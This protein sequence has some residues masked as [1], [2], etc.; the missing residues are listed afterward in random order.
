MKNEKAIYETMLSLK[1]RVT[2]IIIAHRLSTVEG[3]DTIV[4]LNKGQIHA[5]GSVSD[6]LPLYTTTLKEK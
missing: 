3:C 5:L 1:K 6:V 4:W 2:V